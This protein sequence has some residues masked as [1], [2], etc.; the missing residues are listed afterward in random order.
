MPNSAKVLIRGAILHS[1][2][3]SII[4]VA[5]N[6][7]RGYGSLKNGYLSV[8]NFEVETFRHSRAA[9]VYARHNYLLLVY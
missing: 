4:L 1:K 3:T 8:T 2:D 5:N 6:K 9:N 7:I